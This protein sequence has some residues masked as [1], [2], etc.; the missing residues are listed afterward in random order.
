MLHA[1]RTT[2]SRCPERSAQS[3]AVRLRWDGAVGYVGQ[4]SLGGGECPEAEGRRGAEGTAPSDVAAEDC[5]QGD[6]QDTGR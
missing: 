3:A 2:G 4:E 1:F 5:A 6:A